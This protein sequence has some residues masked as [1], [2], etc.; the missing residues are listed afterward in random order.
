MWR[1]TPGERPV[2]LPGFD[3]PPQAVPEQEL[4]EHI[5]MQFG[6]GDRAA[7]LRQQRRS[8]SRVQV[9]DFEVWA[10]Q[11]ERCRPHDAVAQALVNGRLAGRLVGVRERRSVYEVTEAEERGTAGIPGGV[12]LGTLQQP[13]GRVARRVL[14]HRVCPRHALGVQPGEVVALDRRHGRLLPDRLRPQQRFEGEHGQLRQVGDRAAPPVH[15]QVID[16]ALR[17]E[18]LLDLGGGGVSHAGPESIPDRPAEHGA[19][20]SIGPAQRRAR[21][22]VGHRDVSLLITRR[23]NAGST[24]DRSAARG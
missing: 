8:R 19:A 4:G 11:R 14:G 5:G 15:R 18:P 2:R 20:E 13:T 24:P 9:N 1:R 22:S 12:Q 17:P 3:R 16:D 10:P 7:V 23:G 21:L 6:R